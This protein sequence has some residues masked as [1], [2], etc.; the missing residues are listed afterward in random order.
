MQVLAAIAIIIVLGLMA[1]FAMALASVVAEALVV[2][3]TIAGFA[4]GGLLLLLLVPFIVFIV[5][6]IVLLIIVMVATSVFAA[7]AAA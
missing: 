7:A 5:I 2:P 6:P 4:M 1:L 3:L